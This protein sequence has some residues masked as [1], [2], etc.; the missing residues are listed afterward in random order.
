M[1]ITLNKDFEVEYPDD[2]WK[3]FTA[4]QVAAIVLAGAVAV[5]TGVLI[6]KLTGLSPNY[7]V[8]LGMPVMAGILYIGFKQNQGMYLEEY[9]KELSFERKIRHLT[10]DAGE[11]DEHTARIFSMKTTMGRKKEGE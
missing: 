10:F 1:N 8:Y 2:V 3:G 6:W 4:R 11:F 5:G 7:C 9:V